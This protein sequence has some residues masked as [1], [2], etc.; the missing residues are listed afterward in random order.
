[1]SRQMPL[2]DRNGN[3]WSEEQLMFLN[4]FHDRFVAGEV[5]R[6]AMDSIAGSG[7]TSL[8]QGAGEIVGKNDPTRRT[9]M[10]AL[11]R[12]IAGDEALGGVLD[13][14]KAEYGLDA[15]R[16]G[17]SNTVNAAG[18]SILVHHAELNGYDGIENM[19][20]KHDRY[21]VIPR[22]VLASRL[23]EGDLKKM[24]MAFDVYTT[25][26]AFQDLARGFAELI[27]MFC[28]EGWKP[29]SRGAEIVE[30][31]GR[32]YVV[33]K[34]LEGRGD[35]KKIEEIISQNWSA[36]GL[37]DNE[38]IMMRD[39]IFSSSKM[40]EFNRMIIEAM[41]LIVHSA[42]L[43]TPSTPIVP[44]RIDGNVKTHCQ[45]R[46]DDFGSF[47]YPCKQRRNGKDM[48]YWD[49]VK[50][51]NDQTSWSSKNDAQKSAQTYAV[52][53]NDSTRLRYPMMQSKGNDIAVS[54]V[55]SDVEDV[56]IV[57]Y[58]RDG[59]T[60]YDFKN[61]GHTRKWKGQILGF[62]FG[63]KCEVSYD[64]VAL[65]DMREFDKNLGYAWVKDMERFMHIINEKFKPNEIDDQREG[66]SIPVED[67]AVSEPVISKG[68][69]LLSMTDQIYLPV[70]L[71][72]SMPQNL[73]ADVLFV[74]EVQDLSVV[75]GELILKFCHDK[76]HIVI[77]GDYRQSI[78]AWA[79]ASFTS[80]Q[81]NAEIIGADWFKQTIC[82]RGTE[83]VAST[84]RFACQQHS[85][86]V[87]TLYPN[88]FDQLP[89]YHEH[90]SPRSAGHPEWPMGACP[91]TISTG[92]VAKAVQKINELTNGEASFGLLCRVKKP[93]TSFMIQCLKD[94]IPVSTPASV[95][96]E[97]GLVDE[98]FKPAKKD[99][100]QTTKDITM[101]SRI[102]LGWNVKTR[103]QNL[104]IG[105]YRE[106]LHDRYMS[107]H[108]DDKK[109]VEADMDY[110]NDCGLLDLLEA[111]VSLYDKAKGLD[112]DGNEV[113]GKDFATRVRNWVNAVLFSDAHNAVHI[114]SIHRYKGDERDY[115]FV[116]ESY[117]DMSDPS[118]N[119]NVNHREAYEFTAF[120]NPRSCDASFAMAVEELNMVYVGYTRSK[121]MTIIVRAE[122]EAPTWDE[123][124]FTMAF[125]GDY[126]G[127]SNSDSEYS[128]AERKVVDQD[129]CVECEKP[130]VGDDHGTC[131]E[132][133]GS[134]CRVRIP[135][136]SKS[137]KY[138][139]HMGG[140][141]NDF[142]SC[143]ST[144][145]LTLDEMFSLSKEEKEARRICKS[146]EIEL[147][148]YEEEFSEEY[149]SQLDESDD[150]HEPRYSVLIEFHDES[151]PHLRITDE[152]YDEIEKFNDF[153]ATGIL[154]ATFI[155][156]DT[157]SG[158]RTES[159][160]YEASE[161]QEEQEEQE[162]ERE[163]GKVEMMS[164]ELEAE[165]S[166]DFLDEFNRH[167]VRNGIIEFQ[168]HVHLVYDNKF[169]IISLNDWDEIYHPKEGERDLTGIEIATYH[170]IDSDGE[171]RSNPL[172]QMEQES[173]EEG[174]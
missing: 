23:S 20:Y 73:M 142:K 121:K 104:R 170:F 11:N 111:F 83:F 15:R 129:A 168:D 116:V 31:Q 86:I 7:K 28:D 71:D 43:V 135:T 130:L 42:F 120:M 108:G 18:R 160:L 93:L 154:R 76:T 56:K 81:R 72:L 67:R 17:G 19:D 99:F 37:G 119:I 161:E 98:A 62:A 41:G 174:V 132:C 152:E 126:K 147:S 114:A 138:K 94:G 171:Q 87:Q 124:R 90:R 47:T 36:R 156:N 74:D 143:G 110:Q 45:Y 148:A 84:A 172:Y 133:G 58:E 8:V 51:L 173:N 163:K 69:C 24:K 79:G 40:I 46:I 13:Y 49:E 139:K 70:A 162:Q 3:A 151:R 50:R 169:L 141:I 89:A 88:E 145:R 16:F 95:G 52:I 34:A 166:Q 115:M 82:W 97:L 65:K 55:A 64:G 61:K 1:M 128:D 105:E 136:H 165:F 53:M 118:D 6:M 153:P 140:E 91:H 63:F 66:K 10:T 134:L 125:N 2:V 122:S 150:N 57:L 27:Q 100:L 25:S 21:N 38:F 167:P 14:L 164:D 12:H 149:L 123:K 60:C 30:H 101:Y 137:G 109:L 144:L 33:P 59:K 44:Y 113:A 75:K 92:D 158:T 48:R 29:L 39:L 80:F 157:H 68:M 32:K 106:Q 5:V 78:Y 117:D 54:D 103:P 112:S 35:E 127:L 26:Q 102:G 9:H 96:N 155:D 146:C 131:A 77:V 22:I 107:K 159:S 4:A 85:R